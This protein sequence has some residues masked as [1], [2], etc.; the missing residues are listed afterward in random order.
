M[1]RTTIL[2]DPRIMTEL[3]Q[4]A[5]SQGRP[6]AHLIRE[7]MER[8]VAEERQPRELPAFV[9][10]GSGPGD[11]AAHDEEILEREWPAELQADEDPGTPDR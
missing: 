10:M 8:Y 6:T 1:R 11:V 3:E 2:A 5:R 7:A 4:L 9:G